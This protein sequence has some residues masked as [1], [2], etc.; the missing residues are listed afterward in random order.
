VRRL[1]EADLILHGGDVM[2]AAV[3]EELQRLAPVLAVAGNADEPALKESLPRTRVVQ[4][5]SVRI[6]MVHIP[7]RAAGRAE[8]LAA[9]FPDCAAIVYGHT[10]VPEL[11]EHAGTWILNPGSPTE[12]RR[13]PERSMLLLRIEGGSLEPRFVGLGT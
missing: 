11:V 5:G 10:H 13:A 4:V 3:L 2:T 9:K 8:R 7:G 6:G 12:R 1:A